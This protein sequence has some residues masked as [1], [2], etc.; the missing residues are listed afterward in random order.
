MS[1]GVEK[2]NYF[3]I[4]KKILNKY[5]NKYKKTDY[6]FF[7]SPIHFKLTVEHQEIL[8]SVIFKFDGFNWKINHIVIPIDKFI[9]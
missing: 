4:F 8:F 5:L 6:F 2:Y 7:T 3:V 1:S 9:N